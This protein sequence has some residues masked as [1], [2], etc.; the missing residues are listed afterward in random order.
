MEW[1]FD[2]VTKM[3]T[4]RTTYGDRQ[5]SGALTWLRTGRET[6]GEYGLIYVETGP[7]YLVFPHYHTLYTETLKV[8]AGAG[9]GRVGEHPVSIQPGREYVVPPRVVHGWG[10]L[11]EPVTGIVELRPAHE[12]FEKWIMML[13]NMAADGLTKPDL[14]P[15][16]PV[17]AALFLV[18]SDTH[19]AGRMRF[20]NPLFSGLAWV[21]GKAGIKRRLEE[22]YFHASTPDLSTTETQ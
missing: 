12:G 10:P 5:T 3:R 1:T 13:H 20:L 14:Q 9:E 21:A 8:F 22:K 11:T 17:H 4:G 16:N 15:K 7:D 19:L 18:E 2:Q 6:N